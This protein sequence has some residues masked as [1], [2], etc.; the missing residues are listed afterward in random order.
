VTD[1]EIYSLV[2]RECSISERRYVTE[3]L[4][5]FERYFIEKHKRKPTIVELSPA[6]ASA[7]ALSNDDGELEVSR[8][9]TRHFH[10]WTQ[11]RTVRLFA[12]FRLCC[13]THVFY[14]VVFFFQRLSI[15]ER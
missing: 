3:A 1:R 2:G 15:R 10:A 13:C 9:F 5:A 8:E 6:S 4:N 7:S 14:N 11:N 12:L